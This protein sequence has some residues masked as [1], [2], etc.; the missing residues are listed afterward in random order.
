MCRPKPRYNPC[1]NLARNTKSSSSPLLYYNPTPK[2]VGLYCHNDEPKN[3]Q[4]QPFSSRQYHTYI[5][6]LSWSSCKRHTYY[7]RSQVS[8]WSTAG[9]SAATCHRPAAKG[10]VARWPDRQLVTLAPSHL[11]TAQTRLCASGH[12]RATVAG[13][14][15]CAHPVSSSSSSSASSS[16]RSSYSHHTFLTSSHRLTMTKRSIRRQRARSTSRASCIGELRTWREKTKNA[17]DSQQQPL[18]APFL[19]SPA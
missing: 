15:T 7:I 10:C 16:L 2:I 17:D 1:E 12:A 3:P 19:S 9:H 6:L 14:M 8:S 11:R 5:P 13:S 18:V 4:S